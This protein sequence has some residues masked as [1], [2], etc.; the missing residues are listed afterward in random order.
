[1]YLTA[2]CRTCGIPVGDFFTI[3]LNDSRQFDPNGTGGWGF[4]R[5][6]RAQANLSSAPTTALVSAPEPSSLF[7]LAAGAATMAARRK[8]RS[9]KV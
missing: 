7:L 2:D 9:K 6:F 4:D 3:V 5:L 1:M 8:F